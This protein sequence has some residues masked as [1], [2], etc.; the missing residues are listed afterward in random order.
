MAYKK[1]VTNLRLDYNDWLQIKTMAAELGLSVNEYINRL[2]MR[3]SAEQSL[4]L[5]SKPTHARYSIWDLPKLAKMS[6]EPMGL[7]EEDKEIY[8]T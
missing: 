6:S 2:I 1:V 4:A 5:D 7:S 3:K 8:E